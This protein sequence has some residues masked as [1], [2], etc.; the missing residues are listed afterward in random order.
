MGAGGT[1]HLQQRRIA[2]HRHDGIGLLAPTGDF[3]GI[4]QRAQRT[5]DRRAAGRETDMRRDQSHSIGTDI[6]DI[7]PCGKFRREFG[8]QPAKPVSRDMKRH[9][10]V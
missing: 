6:E 2:P 8:P 4:R 10:A 9:E 7:R 1:L 3:A 5:F